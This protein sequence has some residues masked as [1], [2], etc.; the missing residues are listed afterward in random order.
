MLRHQYHRPEGEG[1]Y[2][3][4][5]SQLFIPSLCQCE[6][7]VD[8]QPILD[9]MSFTL[10]LSFLLAAT[11]LVFATPI[12]HKSANAS[13]PTAVVKNGTYTGIHNAAYNQD[14]FLGIPFA[15]VTFL[16]SIRDI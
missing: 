10:F 1:I 4:A 14:F 9:N 2:K 8:D 12:L 13:V 6:Q 15:Q 11:S 16:L 7:C 5:F 3:N